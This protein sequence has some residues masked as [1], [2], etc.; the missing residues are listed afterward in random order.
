MSTPDL[1][2]I[3]EQVQRQGKDPVIVFHMR[4]WLDAHSEG[5]LVA[6]AEEAYAAGAAYLVLN[7]EEIDTLTSA[8][9]RAIQKVF[10]LFN[11]R[12]Q[13]AQIVRMKLC[14]A[15]PP[16]Y[17]V[18]GLTGFLHTMPMYENL[19]DALDSFDA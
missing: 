9:M 19:Q 11:S 10:T 4:G 5:H 6:T 12:N 7:L 3:N 14:S 13:D 18:L 8:G 16:V 17:H 1:K 2:I 15:P